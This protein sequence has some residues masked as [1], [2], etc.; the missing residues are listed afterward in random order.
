MGW[1]LKR[2]AAHLGYRE[3]E[4]SNC[5]E[6]IRSRPIKNGIY[7]CT[8][9][10]ARTS[11]YYT[12]DS[13]SLGREQGTDAVFMEGINYIIELARKKNALHD[14]WEILNYLRRVKN[15]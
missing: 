12:C 13:F 14:V 2:Q 7:L 15:L 8:K 5:A 10:H 4:T 11:T 6:C 1:A 9:H 3:A